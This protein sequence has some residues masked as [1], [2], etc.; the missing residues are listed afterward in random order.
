[1][2]MM[3]WQTS[4]S[5]NGKLLQLL[6]IGTEVIT[7]TILDISYYY[8]FLALAIIQKSMHCQS[9]SKMTDGLLHKMITLLE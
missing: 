9:Y 5:Y 3:Q 1:M 2:V 6:P 8:K 4:Y 7:L